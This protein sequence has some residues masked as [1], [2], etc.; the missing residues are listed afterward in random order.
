[1]SSAG[2]PRVA[3]PAAGGAAA[4]GALLGRA[5]GGPS[6]EAAHPLSTPVIDAATTA[7]RHRAP[8]STA[9]FLVR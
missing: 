2:S 8:L 3:T 6:E 4:G 7:V 5:A 9:W 1:M